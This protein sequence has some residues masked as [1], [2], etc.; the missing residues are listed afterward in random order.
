MPYHLALE[1]L[2]TGEP[3]PAARAAELGLVNRLAPSGQV[4]GLAI[5]LARAIARNAPLAV[6]ATKRIAVEAPTWPADDAFAI[7]EK[8]LKVVRESEDAREGAR[9]F[10]EKR[11]PVWTGS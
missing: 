4:L 11:P 9:A 10:S 8:L 5:E 3:L 6:A 2:L 7:Q 1:L